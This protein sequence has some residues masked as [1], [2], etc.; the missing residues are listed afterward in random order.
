M[1]DEIRPRRGGG[2]IIYGVGVV[3]IILVAVLALVLGH[4]R[5]EAVADERKQRSDAAAAGVPVAVAPVALAPPLLTIDVPGDVR[6]YRQTTLYAKVA[7]YLREI[8]VDRGDVVKAND[9]I[10]VVAVPESDLQITSLE[11]ELGSRRQIFDRT[12][13]LVPSGVASQAELDRSSA[14][15]KTI[16]AEVDRL[17]AL[18]GYNVIR[19][20]WAGTITTRYADPGT[21]MPAAVGSTQNVQP[22]VDLVD[23]SRVRITVYLGQLEAPLVKEGDP[24]TLVRDSDPGHPIP[25]TITRLPRSLDPRTRTMPVEIELANDEKLFYPGLFVRVK[26]AVKAPP[27][28]AIP[29]DGVF[30]RGGKPMV[31]KLESGHAKYAEIQVADDDGKTVRVAGGL[32][33]GEIIIL[34]PGDEISD[35]A[36]VQPVAPEKKPDAAPGQ[37]PAPAA[38]PAQ[39]EPK[40]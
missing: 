21:L 17:N 18:R 19:A 2:I 12:K 3:A 1:S 10:G 23:M 4:G 7:G 32:A 5:R 27:G 15:V 25:A 13:A 36:P 40:K 24:V 29:A 6:P 37:P 28:L 38:T 8:R 11:A 33:A 39:G 14:D 16:Q 20:P 30:V 22:L 9:I 31:A 34:H 35:G 26:I